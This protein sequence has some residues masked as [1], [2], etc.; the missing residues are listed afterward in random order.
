MQF[1]FPAF[2][3]ALAALAIPVIIHLF[4]FRRFK[5]VYFT[6]VRFLR[7]VKEETS[8]R[9]R[10]RNILVLLMRMLAIA[11]LVL[12]FAQ[13]FFSRDE[14]VDQGQKAISIF[15]DNSFSMSALSSDLA[16]LDKARQRAREVVDAFSEEDRFQILTMDFEGR[17]QRLVSKDDAYNLIDEIEVSPSVRTIS[18]ILN[19]QKQVLNQAPNAAGNSYVISDFQQSI[20]DVESYQDSTIDLNLVPLRAVQEKNISIDSAWLMRRC[21]W[22]IRPIR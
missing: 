7:E 14:A 2:L 9:S 19:R 13:P 8:T 10:L 5:K 17:H 20:S 21:R 15:V 11:F 4:H 16:L 18:E 1:L 12:A 3:F 22:L 6:N